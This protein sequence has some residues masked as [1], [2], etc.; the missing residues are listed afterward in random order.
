MNSSIKITFK[1]V[2]KKYKNFESYIF[3]QEMW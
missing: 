1:K 2:M 3:S